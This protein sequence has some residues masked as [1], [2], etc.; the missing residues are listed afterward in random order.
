M[1]EEDGGKW[2]SRQLRVGEKEGGG[3]WKHAKQL[4]QRALHGVGGR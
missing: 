1:K 4:E 2:S 3:A